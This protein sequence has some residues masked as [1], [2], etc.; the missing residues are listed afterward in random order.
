M[1]ELRVEIHAFPCN[2]SIT[3]PQG[4]EFFY[5]KHIPSNMLIEVWILRTPDL[6]DG[7]NVYH[8]RQIFV[9]TGF[10]LRGVSPY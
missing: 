7:I 2:Q 6:W 10:H 3:K 9:L 1:W 4:K 8:E 5:Y